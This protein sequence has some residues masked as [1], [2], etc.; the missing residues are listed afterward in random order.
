MKKADYI[1]L[2][3]FISALFIFT[4]CEAPP[5]WE[6]DYNNPNPPGVVT[7]T[8]VKNIN[9]GAVIFYSFPPDADLLGV[10][11]LYS[12]SEQDPILEAYSSAFTDSIV[13]VGFPNTNERTVRLITINSSRKESEAVEVRIRPETI[14]VELIRKTLV[15][16]ET[17]S[18][19]LVKW[20]NPYNVNIG[21]SLF[22]VDSIG[23]MNLDHT[24]FSR[25]SGA[26]AFRGFESEERGFRIVIRDHWQNTATPLDTML[27]PLFEEDVVAKDLSGQ[28][29]WIRYGYLDE[30]NSTTWRGDFPSQYGTAAFFHMWNVTVTS[31]A[32]YFHA[33]LWDSFTLDKFTG[34]PQDVTTNPRP[35]CV[36][37]DMTRET[38]LSRFKLY[39][40]NT[41]SPEG[42]EPYHMRIWATN[43]T[44]KS[45]EDFDM[46][47][48]ASLAY[49]TSWSEVDGT[50]AWKND[51]TL[52]AEPILIPPSGATE[53]FQWTSADHQWAIAGAEFDFFPEHS[54]TP[55]RY[56]RLECIENFNKDN[57]MQFHGME[58]LG[59]VVK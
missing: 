11:A 57:L 51:W 19:V 18:G 28:A 21:I 34:R 41:P 7:V 55:F 3:I 30:H 12:Y 56:L 27:T 25:E 17:F 43:E 45:P 16:N 23:Y 44:P 42:W 10:K 22:V 29:S 53:T 1:F 20:E 5:N 47:K 31:A 49:W 39:N 4:Q 33:G 46:D 24:H 48:M 8:E 14:P 50:D 59:A 54:A 35:L 58:V 37:I 15:V 2:A 52:I 26:F 9:G 38:K 40:R 13:L 6:D 32:S 36:T